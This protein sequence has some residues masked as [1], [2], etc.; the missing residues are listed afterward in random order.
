MFSFLDE[1]S[2][3]TDDII[4][5]VDE[6]SAQADLTMLLL[7]DEDFAFDFGELLK[8]GDHADA[9]L[10]C[11]GGNI[12][13][14]KA[15][16]AARSKVFSD[17]LRDNSEENKNGIINLTTT[18]KSVMEICLDFIYKG[19]ILNLPVEKAPNLYVL[20]NVLKIP[21]LTRKCA[22]LLI[23][24]LCEDNYVSFFILA[25]KYD[26]SYLKSGLIHFISDHI[27]LLKSEN[28]MKFSKEYMKTANEVYQKC[29]LKFI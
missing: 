6:K 15:I 18:E 14:H 17:M 20:G 8:M 27:K 4:S 9:L 7:S 23:T 11:N 3:Q 22:E 29:I 12:P 25:D 2:I 5:E 1:K 16:L 21:S 28:W 13:A 24:N 10:M 26:D 19:K